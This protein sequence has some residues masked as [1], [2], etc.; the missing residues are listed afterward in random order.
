MIGGLDGHQ[1]ASKPSNGLQKSIACGGSLIPLRA[2]A[3]VEAGYEVAEAFVVEAPAKATAIV[4]RFARWTS[5]K[6]RTNLVLTRTIANATGSS[7]RV[8]LSHLRRVIKPEQLPW[9]L[10]HPSV[11]ESGIRVESPIAK[12]ADRPDDIED[13]HT[14]RAGPDAK[15][16]VNLFILL[17]DTSVLAQQEIFALLAATNI[18]D[19][20]DLARK[21]STV[22][23]P[24]SPPMSEAQA[25]Q[26]SGEYWP[27]IYKKHNPF[28]PQSRIVDDATGEIRRDVGGHMALAIAAGQ[29]TVDAGLGEHIGAVIVDRFNSSRSLIVA[30]AGDARWEGLPSGERQGAGNVMAHAVM[31]AIGMVARKRMEAHH[32]LEA[33]RA[34]LDIGNNFAEAP[35]T[36]VEADLYSSLSIVCGGYLCLDFELYVTHEPC[37][38]CCMAMLHSRFGRVVFGS[39]MIRTGG[40][41]AEQ[42]HNGESAPGL[43]Y[44]LFWRPSL[45]W[46]FLT[47]QWTKE[48]GSRDEAIEDTVHA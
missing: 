43:G 32:D 29:A 45:N 22:V 8:V 13:L 26:W 15:C 34:D 35:L 18:Y 20:A 28:G 38:M 25:Q 16:P 27:T 17:C 39:R 31:R 47:W 4:L 9:S 5:H 14:T 30:V 1:E 24:L 41:V 40:L 48:D 3:E 44:G 42:D 37:V 6:Y 10:H 7:D 21:L 23:V 33:C 12:Q 19:K 2:K 46:K 11:K 36:P